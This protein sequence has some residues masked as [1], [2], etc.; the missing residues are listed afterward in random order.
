MYRDMRF[1]IAQAEGRD[2]RV[3]DD[4]ASMGR[5]SRGGASASL[6]AARLNTRSLGVAKRGA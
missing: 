6:D 1:D 5:V 4:G 3:H 2:I